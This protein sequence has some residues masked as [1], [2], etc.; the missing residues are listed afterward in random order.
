M[1]VIRSTDQIIAN[2]ASIRSHL[3][4]DVYAYNQYIE[5]NLVNWVYHLNEQVAFFNH[6]LIKE[7]RRRIQEECNAR[8]QSQQQSHLNFSNRWIARFNYRNKLRPYKCYGE[9]GAADEDAISRELPNLRSLIAGYNPNDVFNA[10]EFGLFYQQPPNV[11]VGPNP[12]KGQKNKKTRSTYLVCT[13]IDGTEKY[14]PMVIGRSEKPQ[15]FNG[16][17]VKTTVLTTSLISVPGC[18]VIYFP[19]ATQV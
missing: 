7:E 17:S 9:S 10:D 15:C 11:T 4:N 6:H 5:T 12:I 19:L 3:K 16:L 2:C 8:V 1:K 14:L 13:N 18:A